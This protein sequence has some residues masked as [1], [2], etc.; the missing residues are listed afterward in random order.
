VLVIIFKLPGLLGGLLF[1]PIDR[2]LTG[3]TRTLSS[4]L[5]SK[6]GC[7][8]GD[9]TWATARRVHMPVQE[10]AARVSNFASVELGLDDSQA[11]AEMLRCIC[12]AKGGRQ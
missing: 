9:Y 11:A 5:R 10:P 3:E 7:S 12:A 8:E 1:D 6:L 4:P 2:F